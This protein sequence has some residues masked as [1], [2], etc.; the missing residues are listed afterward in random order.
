[1]GKKQVKSS[2]FSPALKHV[3]G[4]LD[5]SGACILIPL[6]QLNVKMD[7]L[8]KDIIRTHLA[9]PD[10]SPPAFYTSDGIGTI[11]FQG[12]Y[13]GSNIQSSLYTSVVHSKYVESVSKLFGFDSAL[14]DEVVD[15]DT[16]EVARLGSKFGRFKFISKWISG[17]VAT[18][19]VMK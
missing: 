3:Y 15:W 12:N 8:A 6:Q 1:M 9:K 7:Y 13:I 10:H 19:R 18:G 4:H 14:F 5:T 2:R 17:D 16:Y 11:V